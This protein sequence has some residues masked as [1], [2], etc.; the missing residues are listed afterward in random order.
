M[1][2]F[3]T[4][5]ALGTALIGLS[6]SGCFKQEAKSTV[7]A[8]GSSKFTTVVEVNLAAIMGMIPGGGAG[9]NPL[10]DNRNMLVQMVRAMNPSVDAWTEAKVETTKTGATRITMSGLTKDF[11]ATGD[12]KKAL[13][14]APE[15]A[16]KA[17]SLPDMKMITS[18]KDAAGNWVISMPG[19][20]EVMGI[21]T[22]LQAEAAKEDSFTPGQMGNITEDEIAGKIEEFKPMYAQYKPMAAMMLKDMSITSEMEVGGEILESKVFKKIAPNKVSWTFSGEQLVDMVDGI[23]NDPALPKKAAKLA[24]DFNEGPKSAK[25]APALREFISPLFADFYGGKDAPKLVIKPGAAAFDYAAEVTKAK[26]GQS[27]EL[28]KVIEEASKPASADSDSDAA[29][30]PKKKAA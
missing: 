5:V 15:M 13:A 2:K 21:F 10:G 11:T 29:P 9:A 14:S 6:T 25:V 27:A 30:A 1:K 26:A 7:N 28:K 4:T 8:D 23:I 22:A 3:H 12:L 17:A 18:T 16:E 20:D 19:V 24:A